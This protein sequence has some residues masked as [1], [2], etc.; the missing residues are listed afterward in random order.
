[1][2]ELSGRNPPRRILAVFAGPEETD[3]VTRRIL[4]PSLPP[5]PALI[6]RKSGELESLGLEVRYLLIKIAALE[7][8]DNAAIHSQGVNEVEGKG[9]ITIQAFKA[10]VVWR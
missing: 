10:G 1:M 9:G 8:N 7:V 6:N 3:Y 2:N 5:K 4:Q